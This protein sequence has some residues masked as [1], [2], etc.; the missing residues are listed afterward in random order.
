V[1]DW[2]ILA[3]CLALIALSFLIDPE[4]TL[5]FDLIFVDITPEN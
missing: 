5:F 4:L 1:A 3:A 2:R